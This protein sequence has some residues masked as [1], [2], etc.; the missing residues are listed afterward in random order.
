MRIGLGVTALVDH[1]LA[2]LRGGISAYS[3][4]LV[5][6]LRVSFP[7]HAF[8]EVAFASG[9]EWLWNPLRHH[10]TT[11]L[12][13]I[14][15][16]RH[17]S[18]EVFGQRFDLFHALDH[19]VPA[20]TEPVVATI[21]DAKF[22]SMPQLTSA[23]F[24]GMKRRLFA[25]KCRIANQIIAVSN[26]TADEISSHIG[27]DRE[28]ISVVYEGVAEHVIAESHK[29]H[30]WDRLAQSHGLRRGYILFCGRI[31]RTK[32]LLR[33]IEAYSNL[34]QELRREHP[35]V[36]MGSVTAHEGGR[37]IAARIRET[38]RGGDVRWLGAL[39]DEDMARV[40]HHAEAFVFPS[41]HE[42]FGLPVLEAMHLGIPVLTSN[43]SALPEIAGSAALYVDPMSVREITT[44][45][46]ALL[47]DASLR[48]RLSD[49]GRRRAKQ[50]SWKRC[51]E[52]TVAVYERTLG[53]V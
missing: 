33:L 9:R 29:H 4:C 50:F 41:L 14:L 7:Q 25:R 2:G 31:A 35:L 21:H 13:N 37:E 11:V 38:E 24:Q 44:G 52:E 32:N 47:E 39:A 49:E 34:P 48:G 20:L 6:S 1:R 10:A 15:G 19:K 46:R 23:G 12:S 27:I 26:Y 28:R 45:I 43:T 8:S 36:L 16:G 3:E 30:D 18:E 5:R 22:L 40:L 42:G 51:A 17:S 53:R